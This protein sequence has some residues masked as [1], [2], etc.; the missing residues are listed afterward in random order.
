MHRITTPSHDVCFPAERS[1]PLDLRKKTL[2]HQTSCIGAEEHSFEPTEWSA[3]VDVF[4]TLETDHHAYNLSGA[5]HLSPVHQ[6]IYTYSSNSTWLDTIRQDVL[7][8]V[9][10][11]SKHAHRYIV[12][13]PT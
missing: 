11:I 12:H 8:Y 9:K 4:G 2:S 3:R 6:D 7:C 10:L 5:A 13:F 1:I